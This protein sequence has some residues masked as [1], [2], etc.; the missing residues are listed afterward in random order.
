MPKSRYLPAPPQTVLRNY[1]Q[2]DQLLVGVS[3]GRDS[4][5]LLDWLIRGGHRNLIVCH[6]NHQLRGRSAEADANF[7]ERFATKL[8]VPV[9]IGRTNVKRFASD[10]RMSIETAARSAR[11]AFFA[12]MAKRFGCHR[13][14]LAHQADDLVETFLLNL[15]RGAGT[16]GLGSI[17]EISL[18]RVGNTDLEVI[19]PLLSVWRKDIDRY[20]RQHRLSFRED[21]SNKSLQPL[22]NRIRLQVIPYLEKSFGRSVRQNIWRTAMIVAEE[23]NYFAELLPT[24]NSDAATL[25]LRPLSK[26]AV[27]L[28]RRTLHKWLRANDIADI[29]FD[30]IE[31]IRNL[32]DTT[33]RVA[34]TNLPRDRHVRR[35]AGNLFLE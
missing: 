3:G 15:F 2:T 29:G 8:G 32:L 23:D 13:L 25:L 6:L 19:R 31:R 14:I 35:R 22:R 24:M 16:A 26:M 30:L 10:R 18:H 4:V 11:Y 27:A 33:N 7:V 17:R 34:R 9:V 1:P 20:V 5:T 28:Q 12:R 21:A